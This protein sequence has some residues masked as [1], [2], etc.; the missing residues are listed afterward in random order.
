[1]AN[2]HVSGNRSSGYNIKREGA[3]GN[4]G[5]FD[6]KSDAES[7]AKDLSARSG[8]GEVRLHGP[9]GRIMDSD[10]VAPG[11]DPH[12]PQDKIH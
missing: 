1:M 9:D 12:P 7:R 4:S 6:R 3:K 2:Y 5:H 10:T 11:H 8:G